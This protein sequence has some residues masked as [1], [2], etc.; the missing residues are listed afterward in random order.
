MNIEELFAVTNIQIFCSDEFIIC[1]SELELIVNI[2]N[3]FPQTI[4][5]Q[6]IKVSLK[7][8]NI[9][10]SETVSQTHLAPGSK[11]LTPSPTSP[12]CEMLRDE[13]HAFSPLQ[14]TIEYDYKQD[15]TLDSSGIIC[16]NTQ[17]FL[18]RRDSH[19]TLREKEL[20]KK[21][22]DDLNFVITNVDLNNGE[23][24]IKL[25]TKI[26]K[27]G[28]FVLQQLNIEWGNIHFILSRIMPYMTFKV[29]YEPANIKLHSKQGGLLAG[30]EQTLILSISSGSNF[31]SEGTLLH[32]KASLG[33]LLKVIY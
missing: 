10:A 18:Q 7:Q 24:K 1:G 15:G 22:D 6:N 5:C 12:M 32:L 25:K 17:Q 20:E 21:H 8:E 9:S 4:N 28:V 27:A 14:L 23:N 29:I 11:S 13:I 16:K 19:N 31:I 2:K 30:V 3:N 26:E 33:V